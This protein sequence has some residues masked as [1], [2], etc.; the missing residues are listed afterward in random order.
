MPTCLH[1]LY[2][3]FYYVPKA[4]DQNT[5]GVAGWLDED[6]SPADLMKFMWEFH[7]TTDVNYTIKRA[8]SGRYD[9]WHPT[10]EANL[11]M[12]YTQVITY[13]TPLIYYSTGGNRDFD[14]SMEQPT[15]GDW[16]FAWLTYVLDQKKIPQT[17]SAPLLRHGRDVHLT[18]VKSSIKTLSN[19]R[20]WGSEYKGKVRRGL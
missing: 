17:I 2:N 18:W 20:V 19:T 5:I 4:T 12:Q 1:W 6:P 7:Q 15:S 16:L 3:T 13:P 10:C 14:C 8:N 11:G 9:P